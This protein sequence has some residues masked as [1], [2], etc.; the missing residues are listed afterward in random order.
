M[1]SASM[2]TPQL[3]SSLDGLVNRLQAGDEGIV[4]IGA[5]L[6][7][8]KQVSVQVIKLDVALF[9][10]PPEHEVKRLNIRMKDERQDSESSFYLKCLKPSCASFGSLP[11]ICL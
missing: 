1:R 6:V 9:H 2:L 3:P 10:V 11:A 5:D 4:V 8:V 7:F